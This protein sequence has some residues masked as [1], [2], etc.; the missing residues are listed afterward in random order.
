VRRGEIVDLD[1]EAGPAVGRF[2]RHEVVLVVVPDAVN[3]SG[4]R[5]IE[6][7]LAVVQIGREYRCVAIERVRVPTVT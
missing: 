6:H 7:R 2:V 1:L 5:V 4:E 3:V